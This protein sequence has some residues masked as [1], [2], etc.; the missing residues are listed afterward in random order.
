[1]T[2]S[3]VPTAMTEPDNIIYAER[4]R[5][6]LEGSADGYMFGY[7]VGHTDGKSE[8]TGLG[9]FATRCLLVYLVALALTYFVASMS[10]VVLGFSR[11]SVAQE[12]VRVHDMREAYWR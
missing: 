10:V 9:D 6:Y 12:M 1:M 5:S 8:R 2:K 11:P 4:Q 3:K 7:H